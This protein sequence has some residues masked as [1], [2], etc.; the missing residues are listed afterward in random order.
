MFLLWNDAKFTLC[1]FGKEMF[2]GLHNRNHSCRQEDD[3][4]CCEH[5]QNDGNQCDLSRLCSNCFLY[6]CCI[7]SDT[8]TSGNCAISIYE[9]LIQ[10]IIFFAIKLYI[11]QEY[12]LA[13]HDLLVDC[14]ICR[15]T[16]SRCP[17]IAAKR[18]NQTHTVKVKRNII[19]SA[20][21]QSIDQI[22]ITWDT[23]ITL[24]DLAGFILFI[25]ALIEVTVSFIQRNSN[26]L[27]STLD[28]VLNRLGQWLTAEYSDKDADQHHRCQTKKQHFAR[29]CQ[30]TKTLGSIRASGFGRNCFVFF[31]K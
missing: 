5:Q 21:F 31:E 18:S 7:F 19:V 13:F 4:N 2:G 8:Y 9:R 22:S 27:Q 1:Q 16:V 26:D 14:R 15:G 17:G 23:N 12:S 6:V 28:L 10:Y 3:H 29:K 11:W 24:F 30:K 20:F 25:I